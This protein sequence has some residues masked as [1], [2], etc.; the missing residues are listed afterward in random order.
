MINSLAPFRFNYDYKILEGF[1]LVIS[2]IYYILLV[3]FLQILTKKRE[4]KFFL[5]VE[6]THH[7]I[8]NEQERELFAIT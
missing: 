8:S 1:L 7:K 5:E 6:F 2:L 3:E 4:D